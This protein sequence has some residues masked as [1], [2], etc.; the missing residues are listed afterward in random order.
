MKIACQTYLFFLG[1]LLCYAFPAQ[2]PEIDSLKKRLLVC[3][4]DTCEVNTLCEISKLQANDLDFPASMKTA[5]MAE[6]IAKKHYYKRGLYR[7]QHLIGNIYLN[8]GNYP[9]ALEMHLSALKLKQELGDEQSIAYSYNNLG[10]IY[11]NIRQYNTGLDYYKRSIE[12]K[13]KF[14]KKAQ[15]KKDEKEIQRLLL[16]I[17]SGSSSLGATLDEMGKYDSAIA[18]YRAA[19]NIH[20]KYDNQAG[21]AACD[22][23]IGVSYFQ[24][25]KYDKALEQFMKVCE[26]RS[27]RDD[28][29]YLSGTF[30]NIGKSYVY[31]N[32]PDKGRSYLEKSLELSKQIRMT[33]VTRDCYLGLYE[34]ETDKKNFK[35]ALGYYKR[36]IK[37]RDS[38]SNESVTKRMTRIQLNFEHDEKDKEARFEQEKKDAIDRE[39]SEFQMVIIISMGLLLVI[40]IGFVVYAAINYR[41]KQKLNKLITQQKTIIEEKQGEIISSINYAK[42]IQTILITSENYIDKELNR[43][44]KN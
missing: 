1:L 24:M 22:E 36:Y 12:L 3:T 38:I 37:Y 25:K 31:L 9:D 42:R 2:T 44:N 27:K 8:E 15:E 34:L 43:L 7:A 39:K 35:E 4:H 26:N 23:N 40:I 18:C 20:L 11:N 6:S 21:V 10:V 5:R 33:D 30:L 41:Q 17:A 32:K 19:Q 16:S 29:R 13:K 28:S 14:L